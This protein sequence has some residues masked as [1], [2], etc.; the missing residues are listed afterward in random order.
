MPSRATRSTPTKLYMV[1]EVNQPS[2]RFSSSGVIFDD[3][4]LLA[5]VAQVELH[6]PG[7]RFSLQQAFTGCLQDVRSS[8]IQDG[9]LD[10]AELLDGAALSPTPGCARTR[11]CD[12]VTC[13]N[14][15]VCVDMWTHAHCQCIAGYTGDDC[16]FQTS[17]TFTNRSLLHFPEMSRDAA[18]LSTDA[19]RSKDA[20]RSRDAALIRDEERKRDAALWSDVIDEVTVSVT[21]ASPERPGSLLYTLGSDSQLAVYMVNASV[22]VI[23]LTLA[24]EVRVNLTD[25]QLTNGW[26]TLHVKALM[27]HIIVKVEDASGSVMAQGVAITPRPLAVGYPLFLGVVHPAATADMWRLRLPATAGF[28]GCARNL[29]VN[30]RPVNLASARGYLGDRVDPP[31]AGRG[32][33]ADRNCDRNACGGGAACEGTWAGP[34]CLC[35]PHLTGETCDKARAFTLSGDDSYVYVAVDTTVAAFGDRGSLEFRTRDVEAPLLVLEAYGGSGNLEYS[36]NVQIVD[37]GLL[38]STYKAGTLQSSLDLLPSLVSDGA[39]HTLAWTFSDTGV[40]IVVDGNHTASFGHAL[41]V[42]IGARGPIVKLHV[43][44]DPLALGHYSGFMHGCIRNVTLDGRM[45]LLGAALPGDGI[46]IDMSNAVS[47]AGDGCTGR[48]ACASNPCPANAA[49]RDVWNAHACDCRPGWQGDGCYVSVDDCA[50]HACATGATCVDSH[51]GYT[52]ACP[53]GFTGPRCDDVAAACDSAPCWPDSTIACVSVFPGDFDCFCRPGF[54]GKTCGDDVDDCASAP[55]RNNGTCVDDVGGYSCVCPREY[56]GQS[57]ERYSACSSDPCLNEGECSDAEATFTCRCVSGF[58]GA[59]CEDYDWCLNASCSNGAT[60]RP[61]ARNYSCE[62]AAGYTGALC[63]RVDRCASA[64][65]QNNGTCVADDERGF[66]CVC[67]DHHQGALCEEAVDRCESSPCL[68]GGSCW[69]DGGAAAAFACECTPGW[70]GTFC[71]T[72]IAECESSPCLNNGTCIDS[73]TAGD[74]F[75]GYSCA[76]A[77]GY[78]GATCAEET[79]ECAGAPCKNNGTCLDLVAAYSCECVAGFSGVNCE[80]D[81]R[82]CSSSPCVNNGTCETGDGGEQG[83]YACR[84][85]VGFT[86]ALCGTNIDDCADHRCANGRCVDGV[87]TYTCACEPGFGGAL[88][89]EVMDACYS[90]PCANNGTCSYVGLCSCHHVVARCGWHDETCQLARCVRAP[91]CKTHSRSYNCDCAGTGYAGAL[92]ERDVD[93]CSD[94]AACVR[95]VCVNAPGSYA[96]DCAGTGYAGALCERDVDECMEE[97][98][99]CGP[100]AAC[101]NAPGSYTC[102][103][104]PFVASPCRNGGGCAVA[105]ATKEIACNCTGTGYAGRW[106]SDDVDECQGALHACHGAATC[107]NHPGNYSC[108]CSEEYTGTLCD[109]SIGGEAAPLSAR[110]LAILLPFLVILLCLAAVVIWSVWYVRRSRKMKGKYRPSVAEESH[111]VP[112]PMTTVPQSNEERLV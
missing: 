104:P 18:A 48:P 65:C 35:P 61:D 56:V 1:A 20:Q 17:A 79:D 34:R 36:M 43:G 46:Q 25:Y 110:A 8:A 66:T 57:C 55:C 51:R 3:A 31:A 75:P 86:G 68:N 85:A 81:I 9:V 109:T 14:E 6:S 26:Y 33:S 11:V 72:D 38:V 82:G 21:L 7:V 69:S 99:P 50:D 103:C 45:L 16:S 12:E 95:G 62:C 107:V 13:E 77:E 5:G 105:A 90:A 27:D 64:P 39:W 73:A 80:M 91:G 28:S 24:G 106:C 30:R 10:L 58:G 74:F 76:C 87:A 71:E 53:E 4:M 19:G 78:S 70:E 98:E 111:G 89:D 67:A 40:T 63:E 29:T 22:H 100:R 59:R 94:G 49:C 83:G 44:A 84:C 15:G 96:C 37:S 102:V 2:V 23:V 88:C 112:I 54:A 32:C 41:R 108:V 101:V 92:C 93:E 42:Y 47:G 52:C 97:A 60:C